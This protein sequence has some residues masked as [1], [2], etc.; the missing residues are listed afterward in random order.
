MLLGAN[1]STAV[2]LADRLY[3]G[4]ATILT[5][6]IVNGKV[7]RDLPHPEA[8]RYQQKYKEV[9]EFIVGYRTD[10]PTTRLDRMEDAVSD[11]QEQNPNYP[12]LP[13]LKYAV[14]QLKKFEK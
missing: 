14:E 12:Y 9:H 13:L 5:E 3:A 11:V 10:D 7:R 2:S 8:E 6:T 1:P 4:E